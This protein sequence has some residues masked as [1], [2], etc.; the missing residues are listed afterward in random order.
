MQT[1]LSQTKEHRLKVL[2]AA[3]ANVRAWLKQV[4]LYKSIYHTLNLFTFDG[5]GKFFVAECWIPLKDIDNVRQA[6]E[7]GV[8]GVTRLKTQLISSFF[9]KRMVEP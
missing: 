6:L 8:V 2:N 9:R 4:R 3:A 1:V 5:I 7:R